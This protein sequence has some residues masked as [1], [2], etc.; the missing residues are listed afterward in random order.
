MG[1]ARLW[2]LP[3]TVYAFTFARART[4]I[5]NT[6]ASCRASFSYMVFHNSSWV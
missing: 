3:G 4:R 1:E 2:R 5:Q 6:S